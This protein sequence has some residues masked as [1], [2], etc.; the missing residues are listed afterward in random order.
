[1]Y[2]LEKKEKEDGKGGKYDRE[3]KYFNDGPKEGWNIEGSIRNLKSQLLELESP[4]P[5]CCSF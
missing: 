4:N 3:G 1:M 2:F 5:C